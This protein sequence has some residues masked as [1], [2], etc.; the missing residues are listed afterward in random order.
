MSPAL[1]LSRFLP[2]RLSI[3]SNAISQRIA[4]EYRTRFDLKV[5]EWRVMAVLGD[6]GPL[7]QRQLVGATFMDKVAVNRACKML[8]DQDLVMRHPNSL[9][10]RSHLLELTGQGRDIHAQVMPLAL[11]MEEEI[12]ACLSPKE[13]RDF[14]KTL[15]K[16]FAQVRDM[17]PEGEE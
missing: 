10:G 5:P 2:Y 17:D 1:C 8:V 13:L 9:D 11:K 12:L 4:V 3:T 14:S 7:T 15:D 6:V 16:L